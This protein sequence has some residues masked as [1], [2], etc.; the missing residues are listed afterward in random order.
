M[1]PTNNIEIVENALLARLASLC[2]KE[3]S[4][5]MAWG[6]KILLYGV[7]KS[8]FV[9]NER[10]VKHELIHVRQFKD[11]G[12]LRFLFLYLFETLKH[13]YHNNKYEVEAR[14]AETK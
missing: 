10:W 13:G 12:F 7:S 1:N 8:A 5:A 11:H 2:I 9:K 3:Q 4:V 6:N 14:N